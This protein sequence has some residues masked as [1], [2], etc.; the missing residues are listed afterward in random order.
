MFLAGVKASEVIVCIVYRSL[1]ERNALP[2]IA[3]F[4]KTE[5]CPANSYKG[6]GI[7]L[8]KSTLLDLHTLFVG[9]GRGSPLFSKLP[10]FSRIIT[11]LVVRFD[12][13]FPNR[14][15]LLWLPFAR[16]VRLWRSRARA[17]ARLVALCWTRTLL[18]SF[19]ADV[20]APLFFHSGP[21]RLSLVSFR[22]RFI[23]LKLS[24]GRVLAGVRLLS[25]FW[26]RPQAELVLRQKVF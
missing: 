17:A 7:M 19:K 23:S 22:A 5:I 12:F 9:E 16:G 4:L 13:S 15:V 2:R 20:V 14:R 26:P 11:C 1:N 25:R 21:V 8:R 10:S 6:P 18:T 24:Y 3:E